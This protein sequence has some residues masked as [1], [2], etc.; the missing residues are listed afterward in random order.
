MRCATFKF[1]K[2]VSVI[3]FSIIS[4]L[5]ISGQVM[6]AEEHWIKDKANDGSIIILE[7]GSI[8]EVDSLDRIESSLWLPTETIIIPD[9]YDCLINVDTG[10]KVYARR[11]K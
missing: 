5:L 6:A 10:E 11:I 4:V 1:K 3:V 9:S 7:D 2:F 8:W